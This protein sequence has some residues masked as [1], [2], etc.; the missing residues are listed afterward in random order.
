MVEDIAHYWKIPTYLLKLVS[1]CCISYLS[2]YIC[3]T[4]SPPPSPF[5][6]SLA[7]PPPP[8]PLPPLQ[9]QRIEAS[10]TWKA[11]DDAPR[12]TLNFC[13]IP[14]TIVTSSIFEWTLFGVILVNV[15]LCIIELSITNKT[16][17]FVLEV[18]NYIFV[19]IYVVEASLKVRPKDL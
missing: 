14:Y 9:R 7:P 11:S 19:V 10:T 18:L 17:L 5:I 12:P 4:P 8:W 15:I 3:T 13:K 2:T 1:R 6:N 16:G